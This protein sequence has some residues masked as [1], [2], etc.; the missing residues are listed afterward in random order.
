MSTDFRP[1]IPIRMADLFDG[2]LEG[3]GV[4]EHHRKAATPNSKCLSDS[5]NFLWVYGNEEGLLDSFFRYG[6]NA[7][8]H[9]L[10]AIADEFCVD[11][12]SDHEPQFW[13]YET[14]EQWDAAST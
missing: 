14:Q 4:H 13:G 1:L 6:M 11:I 9:I 5:R 2:R 12:V 8:Q 10:H 3:L 7:P